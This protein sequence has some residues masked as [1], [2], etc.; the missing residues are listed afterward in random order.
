MLNNIE[1]ERARANMTKTEL[2][3]YLGISLP[4]YAAYLNETRSVPSGMLVAMAEK[5]NCS[6]DYLLGRKERNE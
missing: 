5:F 4:T 2:S 3:K 6:V 1:A